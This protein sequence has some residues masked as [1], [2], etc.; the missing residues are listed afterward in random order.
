ME[1]KQHEKDTHSSIQLPLEYE[2]YYTTITSGMIFPLTTAPVTKRG[3]TLLSLS[4]SE[5]RFD[6]IKY[7][8]T[9]CA[10]SVNGE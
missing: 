2:K 1:K 6:I 10:A 5:E 7:L 4:V 3:D 9:E 8:V